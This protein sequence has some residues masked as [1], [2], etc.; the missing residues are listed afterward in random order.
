MKLRAFTMAE[1]LVTLTIAGIVALVVLPT[2][3]HTQP[4][5]EMVMFKKAYYLASR[6]VNELIND[7]DYYPDSAD[8]LA[9]HNGFAHTTITDV[10]DHEATF[11]GRT[12]G[13]ANG[14]FPGNQKFCGL[15]ATKL[16]LRGEPRCNARVTLSAGGNFSTTDGMVWSMPVADF[17]Q[18]EMQ[19]IFVDV[20]GVNADQGPNCGHSGAQSGGAACGAG[21]A[22]DRFAINVFRDG[23]MEVPS[24]IARRYLATT[25]TNKTYQEI[26]NGN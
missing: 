6:T 23:R 15:F 25:N 17:S 7:E 20:N 9:I 3:M 13:G 2:L 19:Q 4:N 1:L 12:Y 21:V 11:H 8:G 16:N 22:P 26:V 14:D 5:R 18:N 24:A 10:A